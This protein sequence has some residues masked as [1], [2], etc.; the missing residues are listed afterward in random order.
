MFSPSKIL[1][2]APVG[3]ENVEDMFFFCLRQA[4][5]VKGLHKLRGK[6]GLKS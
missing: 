4:R 1:R 2:F 3:H 6:V 5:V